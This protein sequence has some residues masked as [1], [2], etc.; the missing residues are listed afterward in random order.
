MA[1]GKL[2]KEMT[3]ACVQRF[4]IRN[5]CKNFKAHLQIV[6]IIFQELVIALFVNLLALGIPFERLFDL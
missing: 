5:I 1:T 6:N 4:I 3:G 2:R